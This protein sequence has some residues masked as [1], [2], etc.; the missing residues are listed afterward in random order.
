MRLKRWVIAGALGTAAA[1][2]EYP[3]PSAPTADPAIQQIVEDIS[4]DRM[5]RS[6]FVLASFQTRNTLSDPA[7]SGDGIGAAEAW[8]R[9][10]FNKM[11]PLS[12]GR[13]QV[14]DDTFEE[15]GGL[16]RP[17]EITNLV[18]VLPGTDPAAARRRIVICAHYDSRA[19]DPWNG[20]AA[21]PGADDNASGV[22]AVLECA[23]SL[24][25][26]RFPATLVFLALSG[27]E[28]GRGGSRQWARLAR[29]RG[30]DLEAVLDNDTIGSIRTDTGAIGP[31]VVRV[32]AGDGGAGRL[33]PAT[34]ADL[35]TLARE[36]DDNDW[37]PRE[38]ARA[39]LAAGQ[40][41]VP[42]LAV[43]VLY[44]TDR[45]GHQGDQVAFLDEGFPGVLLTQ[46][47]ENLRHLDQDVRVVDGVQFGDLPDF[48][49]YN[50]AADVARLDAAVAAELA[51][52]PA[53]PRGVVL[54]AAGPAGEAALHWAPAASEALP[55]GYR[56]VWRSTLAPFWQHHVDVGGNATGVR[57]P[58]SRDDN[59]FGVAAFD[60]AGRASPAVYPAAA[61]AP[62]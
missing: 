24:C 22:A 17:V 37:P 43:E 59:V 58:V 56:V 38:L 32:F 41:Y 48:L 14:T 35:R 62:P 53:P 20:E 27:A 33:A 57:L 34:A 26:E 25:R 30:D 50:F 46:P 51:L 8:I 29:A 42:N 55:A 21:A 9:T 31:E 47:A 12:G 40:V 11:V 18:A 7:P 4:A 16:P 61:E 60:A 2:A 1:A 45:Y 6:I 52:A 23:R 3:P 5:Q 36:G 15:R 44:R 54:D 10:Q 13:L 19:S 28:Q 49:D 39:I